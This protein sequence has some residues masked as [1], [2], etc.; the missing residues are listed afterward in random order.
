M[1]ARDNLKNF[2]LFM[3]KLYGENY[4]DVWT[5]DDAE[6]AR[7][8][9]SKVARTVAIQLI[10]GNDNTPFL[11]RFR[12]SPTGNVPADSR[13]LVWKAWVEKYG[14]GVVGTLSPM[15]N[16]YEGAFVESRPAKVQ[17]RCYPIAS[18][19]S[20]MGNPESV[21]DAEDVSSDNI[22]AYL[23]SR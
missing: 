13:E 23:L 15:K 3:V 10:K 9:E 14:T 6:T 19:S 16:L 21:I 2:H 12:G 18:G 8:L 22:M 17:G 20:D 11:T 4:R 5:E 1:S 7:I